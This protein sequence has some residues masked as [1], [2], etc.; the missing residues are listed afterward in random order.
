MIFLYS[1]LIGGAL[2]AVAQVIIDKTKLTPARI[3]VLYVCAG[4][5]LSLLGIYKPLVDFSGA[6]AT[7]PIIG[8]G[9][10]LARGAIEAA[11]KDGILGALSGGLT[12][13]SAGVSAAILF[14]Y[15]AALLFKP[16][17]K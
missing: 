7:T 6:G 12:A 11:Q 5:F 10:S 13:T 4:V 14:G 15:L 1:F 8:F 16:K 17:D 9:Y 3:L 2:C